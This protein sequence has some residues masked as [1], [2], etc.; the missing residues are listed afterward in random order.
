VN[1]SSLAAGVVGA[2]FVYAGVAKMLAGRQ[3][4][5]SARRLGV[6]TAAAMIV[7][8][9]EV[10]IGLGMVLGD[11]WRDGFLLAAAALLVA[12]TSLLLVQLRKDVRPPCACF[13]GATQRPIGARDVMRNVILLAL[14][15]VAIAS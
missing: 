4:P 14:V 3:W 15:L 7:M 2:V 5:A 12:F 6:P 9:A 10:V 13:G 8:I 11:A 1:F